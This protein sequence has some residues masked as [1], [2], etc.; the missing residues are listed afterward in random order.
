MNA[1]LWF[2]AGVAVG[3]A[4]IALIAPTQESCCQRVAYGARDKIAGLFGDGE[5]SAVVKGI[6]DGTGLTNALP[7]LLDLFGVPKDA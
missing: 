6:L 5:A 7:G 1:A 4:G 2:V 3:V